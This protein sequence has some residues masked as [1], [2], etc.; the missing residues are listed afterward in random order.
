MFQLL[1][2][3]R[4]FL[5]F[6][7]P[8]TNTSAVLDDLREIIL[9]LFLSLHKKLLWFRLKRDEEKFLKQNK[10]FNLTK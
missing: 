5:V 2:Y 4:D 6:V 7:G 10:R 1:P 9:L 3:N 8:V